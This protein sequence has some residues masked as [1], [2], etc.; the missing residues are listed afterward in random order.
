MG[1]HVEVDFLVGNEAGEHCIPV[2]FV[3]RVE[4]LETYFE[5]GVLGNEPVCGVHVGSV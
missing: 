2:E 3:F 1:R 5:D 4:E